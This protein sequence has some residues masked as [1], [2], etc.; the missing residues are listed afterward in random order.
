MVTIAI[1]ILWDTLRFYKKKFKKLISELPYLFFFLALCG[2]GW[3]R[4]LGRGCLKV[5]AY[6]IFFCL[7]NKIL[8]S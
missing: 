7:P 5:D 6:P 8:Q 4:D 1:L 3:D 2:M